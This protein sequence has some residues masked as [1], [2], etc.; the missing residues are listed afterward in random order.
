MPGF[1]RS[2]HDRITV[3]ANAGEH[4]GASQMQAERE[5]VRFLSAYQTI[6][7]A[8]F[9][10]LFRRAQWH[11]VTHL[12]TSGRQGAAVGELYGLVKQVFLLD[13]STVKERILEIRELGLC[14]V[15]PPSDALSARTVI[16]PTPALLELYDRHLLALARE[17]CTT[18]AA[19][20]P[21]IR[22][23]VPATL[24]AQQRTIV[25][26][27]LA[28][29]RDPWR[30]ALER[31]FDARGL[32]RARRVE[33]I[34][35]LS[36]TSH[37]TL[38]HM[39]V[40]QRYGVASPAGGEQGILADQMAATLLNLTGQNF[41]T[42]RDHIAYLM[43]LGLLE[44]Q[45][46]KSLRVTLSEQA[47]QQFDQALGEAAA[48]LPEVARNLAATLPAEPPIL[49]DPSVDA[50]LNLH[51]G[52]G[53]SMPTEAESRH[54]LV[55]VQPESA[56]RRIPLAAGS[57]TIG[58]APPCG[59][60]LEGSEVSRAHCRVDVAGDEVSVTDLHSTNGTFVDDKRIVD[61]VK[62]LHG[63]LLRIGGYVMAC[64]YQSGMDADETDNTQR[65]AGGPGSMTGVSPGSVTGAGPGG[66]AV[67]R[68]RRSRPS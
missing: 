18:V 46:G 36:S 15:D 39:A 4:G 9:P 27:S 40:E 24:D 64:E 66:V 41:Q 34:R 44:R 65:K 61:T 58:R 19:L 16:V 52:A 28:C 67:L 35:H 8:H 3:Q 54:H 62:L 22:V 51:R 56:A 42:T 23:A 25:L 7:H 2:R 10:S 29:C 43:S 50:T 49:H 60:L 55:I 32:S 11:I 5:L 57:L 68:P 21:A 38:L 17:L 63:S 31:I 26:Q 59:L 33:G 30:A 12:C 20:D 53:G 37:W 1:L 48:A 13:D 14:A 6:W 45:P 47:A